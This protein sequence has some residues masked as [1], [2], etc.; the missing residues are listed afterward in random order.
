MQAR[1]PGGEHRAPTAGEKKTNGGDPAAVY[2]K[3][4]ENLPLRH[5]A[6]LMRAVLM[7]AH[8]RQAC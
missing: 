2:S 5:M 8:A 1:V 3:L 7:P 4:S 6:S